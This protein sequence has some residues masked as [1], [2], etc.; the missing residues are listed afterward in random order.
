MDALYVL[1][2]HKRQNAEH[3]NEEPSRDEVQSKR[4]YKKKTKLAEGMDICVVCRTA[5][6]NEYRQQ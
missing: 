2:I 4:E 1:S 3:S 6:R 5:Q